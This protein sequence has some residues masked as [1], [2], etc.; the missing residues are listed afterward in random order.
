MTN[1]IAETRACADCGTETAADPGMPKGTIFGPNLLRV[2]VSMW[3]AN[4][5]DQKIADVF[6]GLFGVDKCAKST[7]QH[8]LDAAADRMEPEADRIAA[9]MATK[10][11]PVNIDE[12]P[13]SA[14]GSPGQAWLATDAD[15]TQAKVA[16]SRGA[17]VLMERF[18]VLP[19][20]GDHRRAGGVQRVQD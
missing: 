4:G 2:G 3:D 11:I 17:A 20:A 9:E 12:T 6:S 15:A 13:F 8:A 10:E 19:P 18:S 16:G 14:C 1:H 5:T 7:I